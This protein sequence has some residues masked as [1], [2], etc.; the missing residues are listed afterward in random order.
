M[1]KKN[2]KQTKR[3]A[4][5]YDLQKEKEAQ[6]KRQKKLEQKASKV[7]SGGVK[8][9]KRNKGI[10]IRKNARLKGIHVQDADSKR[11]VKQLLKAEAAMRDMDCDTGLAK[12]VKRLKGVNVRRKKKVVAEKSGGSSKAAHSNRMAE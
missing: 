6:D 12:V 1:S 7:T 3:N 8:K 10:R 2:N 11:K 9:I 4:H 5:A